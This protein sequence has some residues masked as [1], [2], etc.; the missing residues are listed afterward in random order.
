MLYIK[1]FNTNSIA[2]FFLSIVFKGAIPSRCIQVVAGSL[3][4]A[5]NREMAMHVSLHSLLWKFQKFR[6]Q[7][8]ECAQSQAQPRYNMMGI[9]FKFFFSL[10]STM[11]RA[12]IQL[13]NL[14]FLLISTK[15]CAFLITEGR[16]KIVY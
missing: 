9:P 14:D 10:F 7:V 5:G 3:P 11:I 2:P 8:R 15:Y 13:Y 1:G 4:V 6:I 16:Q 12:A